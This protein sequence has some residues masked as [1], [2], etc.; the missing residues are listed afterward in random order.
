MAPRKKN[1]AFDEELISATEHIQKRDKKLGKIISQVGPCALK[2]DEMHSPFA[3]LAEAIIYQQLTGKAAATIAQRVKNLFVENGTAVSYPEPHR[4]LEASDELLRSAG[5]S[6]AKTAAIK[7]LSLKMV[8]GHVPSLEEMHRL[9]DEE[10][11]RRLS[12]IRGIGPWTVEML[13]I[14]KLGRLNILP[15]TDY[16]VRK[17]FAYTYKTG[18]LP[19]PK[20]LLEFGE[21]WQPYR[22]VASWY[23]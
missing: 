2:L 5:L 21:R 20:A 17:G 3:S 18:D 1:S 23:L 13:L 7:D 16:G 12:I 22:T 10:L 8:E 14:F 4:F 15:S 6:R 9:S 19:T 11:I